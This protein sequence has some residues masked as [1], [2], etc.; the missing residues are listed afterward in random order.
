MQLGLIGL[1]RM[2]ANITRRL[3][4]AGHKCVVYDV[5]PRS[6]AALAGDGA[7]GAASMKELVTKLSPPRAVWMMLPAAVVDDTISGLVDLLKPEDVLIDGGNSYYRH[8]IERAK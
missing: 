3:M 4:Q 2:G 5:D 8:D 1:G 7:V 6:V